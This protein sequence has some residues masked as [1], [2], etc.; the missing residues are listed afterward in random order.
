MAGIAD[1][2]KTAGVK[3]AQVK[4]VLAAIKQMAITESVQL[5]GFGT[6]KTTI[7]AARVGRNPGT[8]ESI[9]IPE[10]TVMT[11]KVSK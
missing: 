9:N 2:A 8:G 3:E 7:K 10:K 4:E 1:V 5:R 6:F 11:F